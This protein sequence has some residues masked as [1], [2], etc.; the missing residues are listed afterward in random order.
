MFSISKK[1]LALTAAIATGSMLTACSNDEGGSEGSESAAPDKNLSI[2]VAAGWDEGVVMSNLAA[3]VL[4]DNG[5]TVDLRDADVGVIYTGLS[6]GDF[7]LFLDAWLP[8]THKAYVEKYGD[9]IED[10]G[11][12]YEEAKLTFAVNNDSPIT[13]I[14]ELADNADAFDNA[15]IG[16]DAGAGITEVTQN[17]VIPTYG[18]E[19]MD[20]KLS[21]TAA[22]LAELDGAMRRG[23]NIV[24]TLWKPH[25]AYAKFDIRD[26]EDP[27]G[28]LGGTEAVH[29]FARAGFT[30]DYP[31]IAQALDDFSITDEELSDLENFVINENSDRDSREA[32][33]EWLENNP[34]V[35][36]RFT[37][38]N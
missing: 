21:S 32:T 6:E 11:A 7:D 16:I 19:S 8:I 2:G 9:K 37:L 34:E 1:T 27:E 15:I 17:E 31:E 12:W 14:E 4:E 5:Y 29:S 18:L 13:S 24:V 3:V 28:A 26:L 20:Y 38:D 23:D 36:D 22:M 10:L 33:R 35:R 25:W 30:E